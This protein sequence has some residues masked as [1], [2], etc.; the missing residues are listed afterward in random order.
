MS[1][2]PDDGL[3]SLHPDGASEKQIIESLTALDLVELSKVKA[4]PQ[5]FAISE[6]VPAGEVTLFTGAG[7]T[8]KSLLGQQ[9]ATAAAAGIGSLNLDIAKGPAIYLTCEDGPKQMHFRQEWL[10]KGLGIGM[11]SL[12]GKLHLISRRGELSNELGVDDKGEGLITSSLFQRIERTIRETGARHVW[13]DNVAHL[14]AG[15]ENDRGEVTR[16]VNLLNRLAGNTGAAIV[17]VGHPSKGDHTYSG[18]TA[19]LNAVRSQFVIE[20]DTET[21]VRTLTNPKANYAAKGQQRR[22]VWLDGV[23]VLEDD[24]PPDKAK[25]LLDTAKA[26]SENEAFL[27]CLAELTRQRRAVSDSKNA[28][29]FA[30][31]VFVRM[32]EGKPF[33]MQG[34][35]R[36]LDRL[37]RLDR[38]EKAE[39]WKGPDRKPVF[40]LREVREGSNSDC[41]ASG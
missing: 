11:A 5:A 16:F 13:L 25:A 23:F 28:T 15:N 38:I 2:F 29:N 30:P 6:F 20:H 40:G 24:L 3:I 35:E 14:F 22:F 8:G 12:V 26:H 9:L 37:Y 31:K 41:L 33:G 10:C 39:L 21:D 18:S 34:M 17:L 1:S 4:Q 32:N 27:Q 7:S 36:A 19:W